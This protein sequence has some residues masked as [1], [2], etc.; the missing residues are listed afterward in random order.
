MRLRKSRLVLA[1]AAAAV[2]ALA[3]TLVV[4]RNVV[5]VLLM[6]VLGAALFCMYLLRGYARAELLYDRLPGRRR[7]PPGPE[8]EAGPLNAL[9]ADPTSATAAATPNE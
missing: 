5:D 7:R 2:L 9:T 4:R 8:P 6:I 3:V 1:S